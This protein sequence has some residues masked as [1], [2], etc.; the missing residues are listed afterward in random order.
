[1]GFEAPLAVTNAD[2]GSDRLFV[3][4]RGGLVHVVADG[5]VQAAPY[6]DLRNVI[7]TIE[8]ETGLLGLAFHPSFEANGRVFVHYIEGDLDADGVLGNVLAELRADPPGASTVDAATLTVLFRAETTTAFHLGGH[9]AFGPDG[10]LYAGLGDGGNASAA[11]DPT[12]PYG[13]L[14]RLDVEVPGVVSVPPNNPFADDPYTWVYGL[15][16]PWRFS[17]DAETGDLWIADVGEHDVEEVDVLPAGSPGGANYGWPIME[18]DAC[19]TDPGCV[20]TGL[21]VPDFVYTHASGWGSSVTGGYVYRGGAIPDLFGSY[22]FGDFISGELFVVRSGISGEA[23]E[24]LLDT[25]YRIASFGV[26][27]ADEI[28]VV[29]F[30]GGGIYRLAPSAP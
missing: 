13:G 24:Q 25:T 28:L 1:M 27:E 19:Y 9:V 26:D 15:R 23:P 2:D 3:V 6:L 29:D 7:G 16:N 12:N 8:G 18:G 17:F 30:T 4:E 20:A 5:A 21:T 22:V 14:L 11:Q 10:Y